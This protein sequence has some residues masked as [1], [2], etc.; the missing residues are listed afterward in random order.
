MLRTYLYLL[1]C[2]EFDDELFETGGEVVVG[3]DV[4]GVVDEDED[5]DLGE[6]EVR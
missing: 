3:G 1:S 4:D 2:T 6:G 5:E